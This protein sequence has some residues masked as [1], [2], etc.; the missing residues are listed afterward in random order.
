MSP[1]EFL[2]ELY[3][4]QPRNQMLDTY[5]RKYIKCEIL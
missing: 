2:I 5:E 1:K 3:G 4:F